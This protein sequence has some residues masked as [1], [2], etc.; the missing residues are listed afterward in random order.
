M[1]PQKS[2]LYTFINDSKKEASVLD[3]KKQAHVLDNKI[4]SEWSSQSSIG[5]VFEALKQLE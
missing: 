2:K 3:N 5:K 4:A 1:R